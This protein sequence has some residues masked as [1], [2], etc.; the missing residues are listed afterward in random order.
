MGFESHVEVVSLFF[1]QSDGTGLYLPGWVAGYGGKVLCCVPGVWGPSAAVLP[2][3]FSV[4]LYCRRTGAKAGFD[5]LGQS[6]TALFEG[7]GRPQRYS[8]S[9][10][11]INTW[12]PGVPGAIVRTCGESAPPGTVF[13]SCGSRR[14]LRGED[15]SESPRP[16]PW[17]WDIQGL[18]KP[19][20]LF[21][22]RND[23]DRTGA[24]KVFPRLVSGEVC[25]FDKLGD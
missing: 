8:D 13:Y 9:S 1:R 17:A 7:Y 23:E 22:W 11:I 21:G 24:P 15:G 4:G 12:A 25:G 18:A 3:S 20:R 5:S 10:V 19:R 14:S 16:P 2:A 6:R